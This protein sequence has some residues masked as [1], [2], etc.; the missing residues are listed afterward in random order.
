MFT[1]IIEDIGR[2]IGSEDRAGQ[3]TLSLEAGVVA[4]ELHVGSSVAVSGVCLTATECK[5][6]RFSV[7][8][9][10]ETLERT[11]LGQLLRDGRV[12]LELP[13]RPQGRLD[14]H[15]VLGHVDG[16][17]RVLSVRQHGSDRVLRIEHDRE[18]DGL[19][20]EKGSIAVDGVSLTVTAC[21]NAWFELMLI[22]HTIRAT[23][24]GELAE[25]D[26]VNLEYDILGKYLIR[27][28]EIGRIPWQ[29]S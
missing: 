26:A 27:L 20:V 13:V 9:S 14:G 11:T 6:K 19:I 21:G 28:S 18:A 15:F 4:D 24:L 7:D 1:G 17:G 22:P 16:R 3:R 8:V 5:G 29:R 12:N 2:V 23:T 10:T 25:G